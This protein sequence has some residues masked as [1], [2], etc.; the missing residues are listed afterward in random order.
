MGASGNAFVEYNPALT[1]RWI[2]DFGCVGRILGPSKYGQGYS[3]IFHLY[4]ADT[5]WY[6]TSPTDHLTFITP[7]E[8]QLLAWSL[9]MMKS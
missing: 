6:T 5:F 9:T 8:R 7:N 1:G 3:A 4:S 2:Q